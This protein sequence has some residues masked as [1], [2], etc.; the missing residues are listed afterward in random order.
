MKY[1]RKKMAG[2]SS[3]KK[4]VTWYSNHGYVCYGSPQGHMVTYGYGC[5][6]YSY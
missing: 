1:Y 4:V 6:G 3:I 2:E 5:Y